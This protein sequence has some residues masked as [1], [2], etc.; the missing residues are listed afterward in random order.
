MSYAAKDVKA[1]D[2]M[3]HTIDLIE[4]LFGQKGILFDGVS[5][6]ASIVA[7]ADP[8]RVTQILVNL[9]SNAIKFT[10]EGGHISADCSITS[11]IV[12]LT[13]GDTGIG[14]AADKQE[15]IFA[16]FVQLKEGLADRE[17]GVG[18]GLAISRDLARAMKGDLTVESSEGKGSRFTLSL[19]RAGKV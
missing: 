2:A 5:G 9:L 12:R 10:P 4:P 17:A 13:I 3:R 14:I 11:D 15:S 16:P 6:D 8:E 19:P 7:T 18:L 1:C